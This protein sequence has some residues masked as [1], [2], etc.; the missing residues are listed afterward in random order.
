MGDEDELVSFAAPDV[1]VERLAQACGTL[2]HRVQHR[3]DVRWGPADHAEDL[4]GRR[5]LFQ[6]FREVA[7]AG[8]KLPEQPH[9][10]DGDDRLVGEG[11]EHLNPV[12]RER[13]HVR[14]GKIDS[15]DPSAFAEQR[16]GEETAVRCRSGEFPGAPIGG[17]EGI[18]NVHGM[19]L[20]D[21]PGRWRI[22]V[23]RER[24]D[25]GGRLQESGCR[26]L[27]G[28]EME[29]LAIEPRH[30][31]PFGSHQPDG[32]TEDPIEDGG[33]VG[34]RIGNE[35]EDL[36]GRGLLLQR[37]RLALEC[38]RQTL[39]KIADP[40]AFVLQRLASGGG[41]GFDLR[42]RGLC[43]PTHR[44]VPP[45]RGEAIADRLD[46][47]GSVDKW[48]RV[49]TPCTLTPGRDGPAAARPWRESLASVS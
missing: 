37:L 13:S 17:L 3:L 42:L 26:P 4:R 49:S 7:V 24:I 43:A 39:L 21:R 22:G 34:G 30:G 25:L 32:A 23:R 19:A 1:G 9:V 16:E 46:E 41:L 15:S 18:L 8:L 38:L 44:S 12:G 20:G 47:G 6:R 48:M 40:R 28:N 36:T 5:L 11:L 14:P 31:P 29:Q 27:L 10:L 33:E 2:C 35:P 45:S